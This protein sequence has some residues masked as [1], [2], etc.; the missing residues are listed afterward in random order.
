[1]YAYAG[2]GIQLDHLAAWQYSAPAGHHVP[3]TQ[4]Q[5]GDLVFL[6]SNGSQAGIHHVA[7]IWSTAGK[8]NG[9]GQ[10]I[11]AQDFNVPVHVRAWAGTGES[12][13]MPY[14]WRLTV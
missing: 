1:M 5:P 11:E 10:I 4:V 14:A 3:I 13:V 6:S 2:I 9:S 7:M 12:E 8:P